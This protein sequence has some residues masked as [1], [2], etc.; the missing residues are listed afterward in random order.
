MKMYGSC[1]SNFSDKTMRKKSGTL[2]TFQL[3]FVDTLML[4]FLPFHLHEKQAFKWVF[5]SFLCQLTSSGEFFKSSTSSDWLKV[6]TNQGC[7]FYF[8]YLV[9]FFNIA[10]V[11]L[12]LVAMAFDRYCTVVPNIMTKTVNKHRN[13]RWFIFS[14]SSYKTHF[15]KIARFLRLLIFFF[16]IT[17]I[18]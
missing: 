17:S 9:I 3:A 10:V 16:I 8:L 18:K 5:G 4:I 13:K 1:N 11:I 7:H 6:S 15:P 2:F 14:V 12:T